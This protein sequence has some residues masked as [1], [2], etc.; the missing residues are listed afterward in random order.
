MDEKIIEFKCNK[1]GLYEYNVSNDYLENVKDKNMNEISHII[2]TVK[3]NRAGFSERQYLRAKTA[4]ELYHNVGSPTVENFK[5]LLKMNVI[6]NC[7][8]TIDDVNNAEKIFG[9]A[10]S[11]LKGKT[12]R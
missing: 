11:V 4:R 8:V 7:P 1:D 2:E 3:E 5:A 6:K 9:P 10:L 12:T